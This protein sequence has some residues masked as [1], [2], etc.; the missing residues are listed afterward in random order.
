MTVATLAPGIRESRVPEFYA[1][2]WI[3]CPLSDPETPHRLFYDKSRRKVR[4]ERCEL[5]A[6]V[7]TY[8]RMVRLCRQ[9]G[10]IDQIVANL[11]AQDKGK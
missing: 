11:F 5:H 7:Q 2:Q 9:A 3:L 6:N 10:M 4:C 8:K 1:D